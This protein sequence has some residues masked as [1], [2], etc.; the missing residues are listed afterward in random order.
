[1]KLHITEYPPSR[2]LTLRESV[3]EGYKYYSCLKY[4][5]TLRL[6]RIIIDFFYIYL[7]LC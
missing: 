7:H 3:S 4:E 5:Y 2:I 1:M 6:L